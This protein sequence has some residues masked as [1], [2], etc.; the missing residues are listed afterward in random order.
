[1]KFK[2][3]FKS[4]PASTDARRQIFNDSLTPSELRRLLA[5]RD[6]AAHEVFDLNQ[7]PAHRALFSVACET[8]T[9]KTQTHTHT[10]TTGK[11]TPTQM[12]GSDT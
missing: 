7:N 10:R 12:R 3:E 8:Q 6:K 2:K 5:Y 4:L 9:L 1:M 11:H